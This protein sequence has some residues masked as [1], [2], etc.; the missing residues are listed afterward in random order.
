MNR[1]TEVESNV[2]DLRPLGDPFRARGAATGRREPKT[3][4]ENMP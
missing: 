2:P 1:G 4:L 3:C